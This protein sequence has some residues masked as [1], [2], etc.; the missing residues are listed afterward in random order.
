MAV[1]I[2]NFG[3]LLKNFQDSFNNIIGNKPKANSGNDLFNAKIGGSVALSTQKWTGNAETPSTVKYGFTMISSVELLNGKFFN[4][5]EINE[6]THILQIAPQ[7]LSQK[8]IFATN[9]QATRKGVIVESEG[10][11]FRDIVIAGTTGVFPGPRGD[12]NF[13][14][15]NE[16][17]TKPPEQAQGVDSQSGK[18]T[19]SNVSTMSGYE[20]FIKLR[21]F[22]L[23][24]AKEKV[25][26]DGDRFLIFINTKDNQ[27]VIAEPLEFTMERSS[28]NPMQYIYKIVLKGIGDAVNAAVDNKTET[29]KDGP[30]D[31]LEKAGAIS[32]NAQARIQQGRA[33]LN[34]SS[35]F[36]QRIGESITATINGP[37]Q[38][39]QFASEDLK[40]GVTTVLALPEVL[41]RNVTQSTLAI[42]AN[43]EDTFNKLNV[44][45]TGR[46]SSFQVMTSAERQAAAAST[47]STSLI[48]NKI[49]EDNKIPIPRTFVEDTKNRMKDFSDNTADFLG[50][51]D[52]LYNQ[53]KG[54][55]VTLQPDPLKVVSDDELILMG[56]TQDIIRS[57]N[58]SLASNVSFQ[59]D[60]EEIFRKAN[61]QF[62]N[63]LISPEN[64]IQIQKPNSVREITILRGDT[65][66][67]IAQREY[68]N[69][70][71]WLDLV[72]INNLKPP[73]ISD[74]GGKGV[75]KPGQKLLVGDS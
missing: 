46:T 70:L 60:A 17:W 69:A 50:M 6:N 71:R 47:S 59:S 34:Q 24:Y 65:L 61:L 72:V 33:I 29:N 57:L 48:L 75:K 5:N 74:A 63:N 27:Y 7:S 62:D 43:L 2:G 21:Q 11:V 41:V 36:I 25:E 66:E 67:R 73:Y 26:T 30:S 19:K 1:S 35:R 49:Q 53:I 22:F 3:Q 51:G 13:P 8:E 23:K 54:R 40:D 4:E 12:Y 58:L 32:A 52:P 55:I 56:A 18:S 28:K 68:G 14:R 9:I 44:A 31:F 64:R 42:R 45:L 38:Q 16:D 39:V 20:E 15:G 37:L 10:V